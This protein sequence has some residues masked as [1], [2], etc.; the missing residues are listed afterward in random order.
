[1][2]TYHPLSGPAGSPPGDTST[3][4]CHSVAADPPRRLGTK[5]QLPGG[6]LRKTASA[7]YRGHRKA[8]IQN[9][10]KQV[11]GNPDGPG[12]LRTDSRCIEI[13]GAGIHAFSVV[14]P[15]RQDIPEQVRVGQPSL[16]SQIVGV[17]VHVGR[18]P[19]VG[20]ET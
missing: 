5:S 14:P 13:Q 4:R 20:L 9:Y 11:Q 18:V 1:M 17:L 3:C 6:Q 10:V 7:G 2:L 16:S 8:C 15:Q 19:S 12:L